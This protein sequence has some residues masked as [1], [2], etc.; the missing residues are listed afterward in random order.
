MAARFYGRL[1]DQHMEGGKRNCCFDM[2]SV[3]FGLRWEI[4]GICGGKGCRVD[5]LG[6]KLNLNGKKK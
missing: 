1:I 5:R 6:R 2:F 3:L 4:Q